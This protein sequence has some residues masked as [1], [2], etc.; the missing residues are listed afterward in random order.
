MLKKLWIASGTLLTI[1]G[2]TATPDLSKWA[3]ASE[4][5]RDG[6]V[7]SQVTTI[8]KLDMLVGAAAEAKSQGWQS[9]CGTEKPTLLTVDW[10]TAEEEWKTDLE[11]YRVAA[12]QVEGGLTAMVL[13]AQAVNELAV[14][15]GTGKE[16]SEG[17]VKSLSSIG[18]TLGV[19]FP[20][21]NGAGEIFTLISEQ[22]TKVEAQNS[23]AET[24]SAMQGNVDNLA[25]ALVKQAAIQ[26]RIVDNL[27][28]K[29]TQAIKGKYGTERVCYFQKKANQLYAQAERPYKNYNIAD[30]EAALASK[31]LSDK[32]SRELET[33]ITNHLVADQFGL[34]IY[35]QYMDE[36]TALRRWENAS[37]T[38]LVSVQRAVTEW[39]KA[40]REVADTMLACGGL[41]SLR[42][43][44]GN[45][46]FDNLKIARDRIKS[47]EASFKDN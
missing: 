18:S 25:E 28:D 38:Q 21:F 3:Q 20:T 16:A 1:A 41:R 15:A 33:E 7:R 43:K 6:M 45:L 42:S 47:I 4:D 23:L 5:I 13:Y 24:M 22:W 27:T 11:N 34:P 40:H 19:A 10:M 36:V 2:C 26:I 9:T 44:C 35:R 12:M 46:T 31:P 8:G 29:G 30:N 37:K 14:S 32:E 39:A 17:I